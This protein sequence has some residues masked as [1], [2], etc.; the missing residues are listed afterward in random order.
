MK[1]WKI[2]VHFLLLPLLFLICSTAN[3]G[4]YV[5]LSGGANSTQD[6]N[7]FGLLGGTVPYSA[8]TEFSNGYNLDAGLGFAY[9]RWLFE[10]M[11]MNLHASA[12]AASFAALGNPTPL[13]AIAGGAINAD[14]IMANALF[15]LYHMQRMRILLG[16]GLGYA[17]VGLN[18]PFA[19]VGLVPPGNFFNGKNGTLAYQGIA[20]LTF[21][22]HR[23]LTL[24][25]SYHYFATS[26][27]NYTAQTATGP[28]DQ[29][30]GHLRNSLFDAG[31]SF[32][33]PV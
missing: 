10:A 22:I 4:F 7:S 14:A 1:N 12:S 3:A 28:N 29:A 16:G 19:A 25:F 18:V 26:S 17:Y 30:K 8:H 31:V 6:I 5:A 21:Q 33:L 2:L 11:Y 24:F 15:T 20:K 23:W 32:R 9:S 27:F 13:T